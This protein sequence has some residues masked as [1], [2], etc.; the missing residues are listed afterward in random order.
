MIL[1]LSFEEERENLGWVNS[2]GVWINVLIV[3]LAG[4]SMPFLRPRARFVFKVSHLTTN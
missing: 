4:T 1:G 3:V 2:I